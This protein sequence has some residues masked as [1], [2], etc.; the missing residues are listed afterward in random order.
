MDLEKVTPENTNL[1]QFP[2]ISP[3][4]SCFLGSTH[5]GEDNSCASLYLFDIL[6]PTISGARNLVSPGD[7][8][9]ELLDYQFAADGRRILYLEELPGEPPSYIP[10]LHLQVL[11]C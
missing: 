9:K 3:D 1:Y 11:E 10:R 4:G 7:T 2:I 5:Y 8:G 6:H